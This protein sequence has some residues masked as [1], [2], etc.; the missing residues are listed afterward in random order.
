M[1]EPAS[2][3]ANLPHGHAAQVAEAAALTSPLAHGTQLAASAALPYVPAG[4][5]V[6]D[7]VARVLK[8]VALQTSQLVEPCTAVNLPAGQPAHE[9]DPAAPE[10][11]P[12]G[13]SAQSCAPPS[14]YQVAM[15]PCEASSES[16][17][18]NLTNIV[19]PV[20]VIKPG[21]VVPV[22]LAILVLNTLSPSYT[23]TQSKPSSR[24]NLETDK[25]TWPNGTVSFHVQSMFWPYTLLEA[26]IIGPSAMTPATPVRSERPLQV[27][28]GAV[29]PAAWAARTA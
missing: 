16:S 13:H 18:S 17:V 21:I 14:P 11:W 4:Q 5:S 25:C 9:T 26:S 19:D 12:D 3:L 2:L 24:D 6:Q 27:D 20:E 23:L 28:V 29:K 22:K 7:T 8:V 1:Q 10:K 15:K